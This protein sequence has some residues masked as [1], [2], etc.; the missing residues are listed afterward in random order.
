MQDFK[1]NADENADYFYKCYG[2]EMQDQDEEEKYNP[3][4][5]NHA[6]K[7]DAIPNII[8][9]LHKTR[10]GEGQPINIDN[11]LSDLKEGQKN[12]EKEMEE[13]EKK[14]LEEKNKI[15]KSMEETMKKYK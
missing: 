13:A 9:H 3:F 7:N 14:G 15:M 6:H 4:I 11:V 2:K 12:L 5:V 8:T 10:K 1:N